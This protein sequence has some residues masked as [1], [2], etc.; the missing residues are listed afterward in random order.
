MEC[1]ILYEGAWKELHDT[2]YYIIF[3]QY[4]SLGRHNDT[5]TG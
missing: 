2:P 3:C 1:N 4:D 5:I